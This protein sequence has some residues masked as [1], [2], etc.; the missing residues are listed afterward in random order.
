MNR[1]PVPLGKIPLC[2]GTA[3]LAI[4]LTG[5][6]RAISPTGLPSMEMPMEEELKV[7]EEQEQPTPSSEMQQMSESATATELSTSVGVQD[8]ASSTSSAPE[9]S[10]LAEHHA[11]AAEIPMGVTEPSMTTPEPPLS[12]P[13][14]AGEPALQADDGARTEKNG[15]LFVVEIQ[16]FAFQTP[17][18][19]VPVGATV[20]WRNLDDIAHTVTSGVPGAPDGR[21]DSGNFELNQE[22]QHTFSE[23][24]EY[25][26][27][28]NRHP[29]MTGKI[30][31]GGS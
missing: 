5:G 13:S 3:L 18:L 1:L 4:A 14:P 21:F 29:H 25:P 9:H 20:V 17:E 12:S 27:F 30:I 16:L 11:H 28:C 8:M 24:G 26:Y 23:E 2:I 31:V 10:T 6:C 15:P 7:V 22:F 19:R